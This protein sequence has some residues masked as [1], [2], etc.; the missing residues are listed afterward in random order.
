MLPPFHTAETTSRCPAHLGI[1]EVAARSPLDTPFC[2][3]PQHFLAQ[4]RVSI[5]VKDLRVHRHP[6]GR[7]AAPAP[8]PLGLPASHGER[9][10]PLNRPAFQPRSQKA[11]PSQEGTFLLCRMEAD[12][13]VRTQ[14]TKGWSGGRKGSEP[15]LSSTHPQA[16][17]SKKLIVT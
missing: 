17:R 11:L 10:S 3:Q 2:P 8:R 15:A 4:Q 9:H 14:I 1:P 6:E 13:P 16:H 7:Q 12:S 5:P